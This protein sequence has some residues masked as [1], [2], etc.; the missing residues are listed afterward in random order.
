MLN[1]LSLTLLS[2]DEIDA[3]LKYLMRHQNTPA[4][5]SKK[6]IQFFGVSNPTPGYV[7]RVTQAFKDGT[8]TKNG[9]TFGDDT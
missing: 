1:S 8:F 5:V 9:A 4:Y 7:L 2:K 6:L 3:F